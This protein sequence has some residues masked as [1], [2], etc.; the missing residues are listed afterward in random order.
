VVELI[1]NIRI[2]AKLTEKEEEKLAQEIYGFI[3]GKIETSYCG[4]DYTY[5]KK[6]KRPL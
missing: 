3:K 2:K 1:V 6:Q 5:E 4:I